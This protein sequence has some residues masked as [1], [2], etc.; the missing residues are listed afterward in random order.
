MNQEVLQKLQT[1][2]PEAVTEKQVLDNKTGKVSFEYVLKEEFIDLLKDNFN[3]ADDNQAYGLNFPGKKLAK[4]VASEPSYKTLKLKSGDGVNEDTTENVYIEGDNLEVLK[5]LKNAYQGQIKMIYIDPPY[6]TGG[7]GFVYNDDFSESQFEYWK[8]L[9]YINED[10]AKLVKE[11]SENLKGYKH[12]G[13]LTFMYPR[14]KLAR[15]L[16]RDDGVIFISIDDNEVH[17]LRLI[18]DEIFGADNFVGSIIWKNVTDN[19]PTKIAVEHEYIHVYAKSYDLLDKEWKTQISEIKNLLVKI[20]QELINESHGN[21]SILKKKYAQWYKDNKNFLWPLDRYK[22]IDF[23]GIYTGSQSVHNPGKEGYRY[24]VIHPITGEACKQPLMGYRF[25]ESTMT[26][27]IASEKIIF[28]EDESKIIELK[29]YAR[30]Y[31]E[32]LPS[33]VEIDGRLGD[34]DLKEVFSNVSKIFSN[35]K[36]L[37]LLQMIFSFILSDGDIVLD[38]FSGSATT[39][40]AVMKQNSGDGDKR[41]Y[42]CVQIPE[43]CNDDTETGKNAIKFLNG[44]N[45]P[46]NICEIG[47]ER[48]RRAGEKILAEWETKQPAAKDDLLNIDSLFEHGITDTQPDIGFKVFTLTDSP[49]YQDNGNIDD[50]E[51]TQD[52]LDNLNL[53]YKFADILYHYILRVGVTLDKPV[54]TYQ[55]DNFNYAITERKLLLLDNN[56][57]CAIA[58]KIASLHLHE[59]DKLYYTVNSLDVF[60]SYTE[61][62]GIAKRYNLPCEVL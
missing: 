55:L 14:L 53:D 43:S 50:P 7:D 35:P 57:T 56:L 3:L 28:G 13:W 2:F 12:S 17:N 60:T 16:L 49:L 39:A 32:K 23:G 46:T 24:D 51:F 9:G 31:Q 45:K 62:E 10:G 58:E 59:I 38:F 47:K 25:P 44:L 40:H 34:Y 15:D 52:M 26:E 4:L 6:N 29:L 36:P 20:G 21:L 41:K 18:C 33:V 54:A 27:L 8:K 42:I 48:I 11:N 37:R 19:N 1:V 22:H 30:D 61:I 5:V